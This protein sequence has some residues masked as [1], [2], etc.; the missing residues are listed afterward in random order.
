MKKKLLAGLAVGAFMFGMAGVAQAL[1]ITDAGALFGTDVGDIDTITAA[2]KL[3]DSGD[4]TEVDWVNSLLSTSY[5]IADLIKIETG[6]TEW[7]WYNTTTPS[8]FAFDLQLDGEAFF[9]KTGNFTLDIADG[10]N[11]SKEQ[12]ELDKAKLDTLSDH[13]LYSN[14]DS[15]D[16]A[17]VSLI[18]IGTTLN[19]EIYNLF[20]TQKY[21]VKSS[22]LNL[23]K[24]S[25]IGEVGTPIPEP[26]TML[27]MGTGLAGLAAAQ[28]RRKAKKS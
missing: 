9:V 24:L 12:K 20:G 22:Q 13:F 7:Q 10:Y 4:A 18:D 8:V 16:W 26:A 21:T 28:R 14:G 27:L 17:V 25:H 5:T 1:T 19:A 6:D 11:P 2:D 15:T 23:E 3:S